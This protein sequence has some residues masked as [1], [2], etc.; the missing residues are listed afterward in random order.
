MG[1]GNHSSAAAREN[2][3]VPLGSEE[4]IWFSSP[5]ANATVP[6]FFR[7]TFM[8][9]VVPSATTLY[10]AGPYNWD[11]AVNGQSVSRAALGGP[12]LAHDRPVAV[13]DISANLHAG[14]NT[15]AIQTS[16]SEVMAFKIIPFAEG[17]S[18]PALVVSDGSWEGSTDGTAWGPV[19]D[20]G[21]I[22]DDTG[23]FR[24]NFDLNM[25]RW[26][27]YRGITALMD[28]AVVQPAITLQG[29]DTV[30]LD[31]GREMFGRVAAISGSQAPVHLRLN[32][33]ESV[34]EA[35][36]D[37][38]S[39]GSR[40]LV[41]PGGLNAHGPLSGFRYVQV[42]FLDAPIGAVRFLGERFLYNFPV[43][44]QFQSPDPQLTDIWN[45]SAYTAQLAMQIE[46]F[47]GIK[48]DRNP[49]AADLFVTAR[50]ARAAFGHA[51]DPLVKATLAD[52]LHRV[53][54]TE[55]IPLTGHDI[56]CIPSFN[57][58]W[59][60]SLA[61]LYRFTGDLAYLK[62]QHDNLV[63]ILNVMGTELNG[64]LFQ[65]DPGMT[66]F[67]DWAPGMFQFPGQN[68]PEAVKVTTMTYCM[69]FREG[70]FLLAQMGDSA[71][72]QAAQRTSDQ[73]KSAALAAYFDPIAGT[74][75]DRVQTNAVAIFS[76]IADPSSYATIFARVL[77]AP[78]QPG[79]PY[80]YYFVLEALERTG[81]HA[82]AIQLTKV[83]W[84]KMLGAGATSFWE[85][86]DPTCATR[87]EFHV[88]L[89]AFFN[90]LDNQESRL[91]IS[92]AHGWSSGPAA[93]LSGQ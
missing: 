20:L 81:H 12:T 24:D 61:D 32:Y 69:S 1:C 57:S 36:P 52:L 18:A 30:L 71:G 73:I 45:V 68:A 70:A 4:Y 51:T 46:F 10:F 91:F 35:T 80:F 14:E 76:G 64:G 29:S 21:S 56:N 2:A 78:P 7:K 39:L 3:T 49:F 54:I 33:G 82:E 34:F 60:L 8:L 67:V 87:P 48:R 53:C 92:L 58:W 31:F 27:G 40:D 79:T 44:S 43:V 72:A 85:V 89:V 77:N 11:I 37:L 62:S 13:V 66:V 47:D 55:A 26:P 25:Y 74:F 84:G 86:W 5:S 93:F 15:L 90:S 63:Q 16:G 88:C 23:R 19:S 42:Q 17:F 6:R 75:G 41:V 83:V 28:R 65:P 50:A 22:E 38:S 59:I 9:K